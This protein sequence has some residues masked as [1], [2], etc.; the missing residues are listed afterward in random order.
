MTV[1]LRDKELMEKWQASTFKSLDLLDKAQDA[2]RSLDAQRWA[3]T[4]AVGTDKL[5]ILAGRPTNIVASVHEVRHT[6]PQLASRLAQIATRAGVIE[7]TAR[8]IKPGDVQR[9]R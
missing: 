7:T 2:G 9:L 6:L 1:Q 8:E 5:Q 3:V 4:A